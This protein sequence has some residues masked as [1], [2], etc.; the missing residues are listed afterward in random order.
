[1][2]YRL[3]IT[4]AAEDELH[5]IAAWW[6]AERSAE[7]AGRWLAGFQTQLSSLAQMPTRCPLAAETGL[8]SLE[9]REL[10]YGLSG[11]ATHRAVFTIIEDEADCRVVILAIRHVSRDRLRAENLPQ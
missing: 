9:L 7:Q 10:H 3:E 11:R 5:S 4:Q 6:A 2:Q 8:L 1:M